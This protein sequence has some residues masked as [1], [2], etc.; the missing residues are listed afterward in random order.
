M[1]DER[2]NQIQ[3][4]M[5]HL[6]NLK[7]QL[8][9]REKSIKAREMVL[10]NPS[11]F[12]YNAVKD[13][14]QSLSD[15]LAPH[16]MPANV[17]ALNEVAWPFFFQVNID[18]GLNPNI[19]DSLIRTNS[20]QIDQEACFLLMS[21]S[22]SFGVD[23]SLDSATRRAPLSLDIIDRQ[24]SRRFSSNPMPLQMIGTN[25]NP[26]ILPTSM[27]VYPNAFLDFTIR[28]LPPATA[29]QAFVGSGLIQL[30]CFG[31]RTR[32]ENAQKV[33]STIFG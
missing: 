30:S 8:R 2:L 12:Q 10:A 27:F 24:S 11:Q 26:T 29:P 3:A 1:K 14:K 18:L 7:K 31:Y 22:R 19:S 23:G 33:L 13:L 4:E 6:D 16:M 25:S 17:G 32:I 21:I 5:Q 20:F 9:N 15:N 28:G